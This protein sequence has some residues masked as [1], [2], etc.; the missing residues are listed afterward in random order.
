M[1]IV[2][3]SN[4]LVSN[5]TNVKGIKCWGA[6]SG[7]K[8]LRRDLAII[9]S[10]AVCSA[11]ATFTRNDVAAEP[12]KL[13]KLHLRDN[14]AQAVVIN[15]GNANA[16]TGKQGYK[17]AEAMA[18]TLAEELGIK[19]EM[20]LVASTGII[21]EPFPTHDIVQGIRTS[22]QNLTN[23]RKA[24]TFAANAILTTDTF[25]KEGQTTFKI[26]NK[27]INIA[28]IAKGSGMIHP[29]MGTMLAFIF[30][31]IAIDKKLLDETV[32]EL[33]DKTFNMITVDGDTS[34]NDMAAVLANGMA[35]NKKIT[36]KKSNGYKIF[37]DHLHEVM[38]HLA[39]LIVSDGEGSSKFIEYKVTNAK[40]EKTA[41]KLVREIQNSL[42]VKTA[43]FGRD[44]NWGRIVMAAGNAGVRFNYNK[45]NL[46]LGDN[47]TLI[48]VLEKGKPLEINRSKVKKILRESHIRLLLELNTGT[49][50]AVGW[51]SDITTDYVLFN[52]AYTT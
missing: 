1:S 13:S 8:S 30:T 6:H 32:K 16:C 23:S 9:Y 33:V 7:I 52:S 17:G 18:V 36:S 46:F 26:G 19:K 47:K 20:V 28:G 29:N 2:G 41:R 34:T 38:L 40:T 45:V 25:A 24:G 43:F 22:V 48:Q 11:A 37:Y 14:L 27:E 21:G 39:Q 31:D 15:A 12:V 4:K 51:G 10:E 3:K 35:G 50:E 5:I 49:E 42:L 44:P